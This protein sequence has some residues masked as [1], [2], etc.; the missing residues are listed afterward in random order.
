[1]SPYFYFFGISFV[2]MLL[3]KR[4]SP[5]CTILI[6]L[7]I[8]TL[9]ALFLIDEV[10]EIKTLKGY[11]I[12]FYTI[13]LLYLFI[14]PWNK[15][16]SIKSIKSID[17]NKADRLFRI[18]LRINIF[19]SI[20]FLFIAINT[21]ISVSDIFVFKE[22]G[23]NYSSGMAR[24]YTIAKLL[25][26]LGYLLLPFHFYYLSKGMSRKARLSFYFSLTPFFYG[27]TYFSRSHP[28]HFILTYLIL[29]FILR[30]SLPKKR[31]K[32]IQKIGLSLA[33]LI[34]FSLAT[35]TIARFQY[36]KYYGHMIK[37]SS[38]IQDITLYSTFDYFSQWHYYNYESL[39]SFKGETMRG[40]LMFHPSGLIFRILGIMPHND[41]EFLNKRMLLLGRS[42]DK[43]IGLVAYLVYDF[44]F[45]IALIIGFL[46]KHLV[47][48][49]RPQN[50]SI[51]LEK[52]FFILLLVQL[53]LFSI[54]YSYAAALV[55]SLLFFSPIYSYIYYKK[56]AIK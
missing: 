14:V 45:I 7:Q 24:L 4:K 32:R 56:N 35:I 33:L 51:T 37:P 28:V 5:V 55:L 3:T 40:Q 31:V 34:I 42:Y 21:L 30:K 48:K 1:M 44:G 22:Q 39:L 16:H 13:S 19:S 26:P 20:V 8:G 50:N 49:M 9:F 17:I 15:Y 46:Y 41:S 29:Y 6:L 25:V 54:F 52:L 53:P 11:F 12:V 18:L 43:F 23:V 10:P 2:I 36:S 47:N 27:L 38:K